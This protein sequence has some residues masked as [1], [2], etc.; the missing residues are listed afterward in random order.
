MDESYG[1][2][3]PAS[4]PPSDN[5]GNGRDPD[6]GKFLTGNK[7]AVGGDHFA[8]VQRRFRAAFAEYVSPDRMRRALDAYFRA[9]EAGEAWAIRDFLDRIL[10]KPREHVI[11]DGNLRMTLVE[12]FATITANR[13]SA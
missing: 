7:C 2:S 3:P 1:P 6:T 10:G 5:G 8:P 9:I 12:M 11:L 4:D 13:Q